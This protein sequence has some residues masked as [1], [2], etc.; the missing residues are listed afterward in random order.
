MEGQVYPCLKMT[1][2]AITPNGNLVHLKRSVGMPV[3][4]QCW[5]TSGQQPGMWK[6]LNWLWKGV[7]ILFKYW[8]NGN[9]L[10]KGP[11]SINQSTRTVE[12][13]SSYT[14]ML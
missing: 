3:R 2:A 8:V 11:T 6:S 10:V 12:V 7:L 5:R 4:G 9:T 13:Y 1:G 14:F